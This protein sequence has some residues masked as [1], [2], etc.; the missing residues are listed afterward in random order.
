SPYPPDA[1]PLRAP[2]RS[3]RHRH[4]VLELREPGHVE[5][6][7]RRGPRHGPVVVVDQLTGDPEPLVV[8]VRHLHGVPVVEPEGDNPVATLRVPHTLRTHQRPTSAA[9]SGQ[10][11]PTDAPTMNAWSFRL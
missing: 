10:Y 4:A 1:P 6:E 8:V 5:P 7:R 9:C 11:A 3:R 2:G